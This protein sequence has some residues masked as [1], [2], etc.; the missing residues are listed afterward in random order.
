MSLRDDV[1]GPLR[2]QERGGGGGVGLREADGGLIEWSPQTQPPAQCCWCLEPGTMVCVRTAWCGDTHL[3]KGT[4][5]SQWRTEWSLCLSPSL[6]FLFLFLY[7]SICLSFSPGKINTSSSTSFSPPPQSPKTQL[8][9]SSVVLR[10]ADF[11]IYQVTTNTPI[12]MFMWGDSET[13]YI[14]TT[15]LR[16]IVCVFLCVL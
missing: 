1:Y 10:I 2:S 9:S 4:E 6:S 7:S 16:V 3:L 14:A 12:T 5:V 8:M 11:S 13:T 15:D